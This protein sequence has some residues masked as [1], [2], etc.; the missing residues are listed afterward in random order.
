MGFTH[1]EICPDDAFKS[2]S[3]KR[4]KGSS[5]LHLLVLLKF[6]GSNSNEAINSKLAQFFK[7]SKGC[8]I[9]YLD[10]MVRVMLEHY[11]SSVFW[12]EADERRDIAQRTGNRY[13]FP[14]CVGFPDRTLLPL[15]VQAT[16]CRRGLLL[17]EIVLHNECLD[18]LR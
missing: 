12:Q 17:L 7:M 6:L 13:M 2:I 10:T 11:D 15:K 9:N 14:N 8:L 18:N 1:V 3:G 4:M 5:E 16:T